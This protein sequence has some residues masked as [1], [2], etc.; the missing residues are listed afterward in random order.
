MIFAFRYLEILLDVFQQSFAR[1]LLMS[2]VA[3]GVIA[4]HT[5]IAELAVV[6]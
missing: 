6:T 4:G 1:P 2:V 5:W 3:V